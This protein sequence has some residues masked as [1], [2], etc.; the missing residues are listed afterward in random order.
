[1]TIAL[2]VFTRQKCS[3]LRGYFMLGWFQR[4]VRSAV[5]VSVF[6]FLVPPV[7]GGAAIAVDMTDQAHQY[8][9]ALYVVGSDA[10]EIGVTTIFGNLGGRPKQEQLVARVSES[11]TLLLMGV[12]FLV[13]ARRVRRSRLPS[14]EQPQGEA[15]RPMG[16][17]AAGAV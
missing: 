2:E 14:G 5:L 16:K 7:V 13:L 17:V 10:Y 6:V 3:S 8:L 4:I 12:G 9:S 15:Q 11:S 1:V